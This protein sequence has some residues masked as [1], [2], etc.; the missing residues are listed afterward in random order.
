MITM[1]KNQAKATGPDASV[2]VTA[3]AGT[4]KT[5]VLTARVLR[6]LLRGT[7]ANKIL[8]LT[9]TKAAAAEMKNRIL[10]AL[11]AWVA[12]DDKALARAIN[13]STSEKADD[14][15]LDRGRALFAEVLDA[16]GGLNIQNFHS[17]CQ[18]LLGR[19]PVEA[20]LS[21]RFRI[22][23]DRT[24]A[25]I[26]RTAVDDTLAS[27]RQ[28]N[29]EVMLKAI[30]RIAQ[31]VN[32]Q[33]FEALISSL[34]RERHHF[35]S[36]LNAHSHN[37]ERLGA[38][39]YNRLGLDAGLDANAYL[40]GALSDYTLDATGLRELGAALAE[41]SDAEVGKAD[42][43]NLLLSKKTDRK[44]CYNAFKLAFLRKTDGG[45]LSKIANKPT[46]TKYP[47]VELIASNAQTHVLAI[48]EMLAFYEVAE[49]TTAL[50]RLA[51]NVLHDYQAKKH[52]FGYV[53]YDDLILETDQLLSTAEIAPWILFKLDGGIDHI[54]VDEAQDTNPEQW[55]L[56]KALSNEF[57]A[58]ASARETGRT[59][60]AVGDAK[61]SIYGFQRADPRAFQAA[62]HHVEARANDA[63]MLFCPVGLNESF[64]STEAVLKVVDAVFDSDGA[65][66]G[67]TH[68]G[69]IV[70]HRAHRE[71][72]PGLVE[73]WPSVPASET[74]LPDDWTV[75]VEQLSH[76]SGES[77][78]AV[79]IADRIKAMTAGD[80]IL[81]AHNRPIGAGDIMVLV[82]RRTDFID[83]LVK[84][85]KQR[86]VAVAGMD[87]MNLLEQIAVMDLIALGQ[88]ALLPGD[89]LNLAAVL[90]SP[91]VRIDEDDLYTLAHNRGDKS[92]WQALGDQHGDRPQFD[93]AFHFL[94]E[95]LKKADFDS[96]FAFYAN[97]LTRGGRYQ[98]V[99]RLGVDANDAIDEF[100]HLTMAFK[101]AIN[102]GLQ[103]FLHWLER[104]DTQIKRDMEQT[105]GEVRIIT[106]HSAKG[107][108]AP[109]VF[110]P[111]TCSVPGTRTQA[112][113]ITIDGA[114][115]SSEA[116]LVWPA[117]T[118]NERGLLALERARI[119]TDN[120]A[121]YRRLLYV[122]MTRAKDRLYVCGWENKNGRAD[123]CWYDLVA[124]GFER[125]ETEEIEDA[126]LGTLLR[127]K[128]GD[129]VGGET[130]AAPTPLA[131]KSVPVEDWLK[132]L[133]QSEETPPRPLA[134]SAP[135]EAPA[136]S[137]PRRDKKKSPYKRG[138]LIHK[139]LEILPDV[140]FENRR[141]VALKYLSRPANRLEDESPEILWEKVQRVL[142]DPAFAQ[143]FGPG[144]RA[145]VSLTGIVA[146]HIVA[147]QIDRLLVT[148]DE[149]LIVDFKSNRPPP[150]S[151][152][153]VA[154]SYLR[155]MAAYR[156]LL[157]AIYPHH[158][159]K[160]A[161]LWSEDARL[162]ALDDALLDLH[163]P[164]DGH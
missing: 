108:E 78:L 93:A 111:D 113:L 105:R 145:E 149:V 9:F 1:T 85:L 12:M 18:S 157:R 156:A 46:L 49:N 8:C 25:D 150:A 110:L 106:I 21:P 16:P 33:D 84:A 143:I 94:S 56:V 88:F 30:G 60:F 31:R 6:L 38:A 59:V 61:Q 50:M 148:D 70:S 26:L 76:H 163:D 161:L 11:G 44:D 90:R 140:A 98:L 134:P 125:L 139:L 80:E 35:Q 82:R 32:Q 41:G 79:Q 34:L 13:A 87:R 136:L 19:F 43:I 152:A 141:A 135:E 130:E 66:A 17:F 123:G 137:S 83:H 4:G 151:A 15:M 42:A 7:P 91:F 20:M 155:Q 54:L 58:G 96:P 74:A 122:A 53:D 142:D 127:Y 57:F 160:T 99:E 68:D 89:D 120:E 118:H 109:I 3:S 95:I 102:P 36:L 37:I 112:P 51:K 65:G 45:P 71:G 117:G 97:I 28:D 147:A 153:D 47:D 52:G 69:E 132:R 77:Q 55:R 131:G 29:D 116:F 62:R 133:P 5:H 107:L 40:E 27:A 67:L 144:S 86:G 159:V 64:R 119:K 39:L 72:A 104:G 114:K 154:P 2:W 146:M 10:E 14:A 22:M 48:E 101:E 24:A 115:M 128:S 81:E 129:K 75:P 158:Q 121:E 164:L 126:A 124:A 23:D 162:M 103:G 63:Q 138:L 100:L 73:L 92:L